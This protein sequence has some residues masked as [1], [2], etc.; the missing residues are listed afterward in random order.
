[1]FSM[2]TEPMYKQLV[3]LGITFSPAEAV[4]MKQSLSPQPWQQEVLQILATVTPSAIQNLVAWTP[5]A[6]AA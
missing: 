4:S 1:M 5:L 2:W 6:S 3:L